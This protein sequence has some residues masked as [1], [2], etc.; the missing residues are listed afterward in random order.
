ME[1]NTRIPS[2]SAERTGD[3]PLIKCSARFRII[4]AE[5][6]RAETR[7]RMG[8]PAE[9]TGNGVAKV[10]YVYDRVVVAYLYSGLG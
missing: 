1:K 7:G 8:Y 10:G 6:H 9:Y 5:M 3:V 4:A 2:D